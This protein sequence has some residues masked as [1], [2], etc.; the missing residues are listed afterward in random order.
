MVKGDHIIICYF[1]FVYCTIFT[2]SIPPLPC[3]GSPPVNLVHPP[4]TS[5]LKQNI[6]SKLRLS[7]LHQHRKQMLR[8]KKSCRQSFPSDIFH[9]LLHNLLTQFPFR[10]DKLQRHDIRRLIII[11]YITILFYKHLKVGI[12]G[13]L[14]LCLIPC[15]VLLITKRLCCFAYHL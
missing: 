12:S 7:S 4:R 8:S 9:K 5:F 15:R 10:N 14:I 3:S 2:D 13:C 1:I 11:R 6:I